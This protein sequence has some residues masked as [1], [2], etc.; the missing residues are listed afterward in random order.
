MLIPGMKLRRPKGIRDIN[1]WYKYI[2]SK[3]VFI[4]KI[5]DRQSEIAIENL[6][7]FLQCPEIK[8]MQYSSVALTL[9]CLTLLIRLSNLRKSGCHT[10]KE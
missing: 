2:V 8:L 10:T 4:K 5:F 1:L 3:P 9:V 6:N 7:R